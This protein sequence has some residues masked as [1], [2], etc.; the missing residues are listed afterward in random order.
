M[1]GMFIVL[2]IGSLLVLARGFPQPRAIGEVSP[3]E[4][5][6]EKDALRSR[7]CSVSCVSDTH[8]GQAGGLAADVLHSRSHAS[9]QARPFK[10][11]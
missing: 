2:V 6:V 7:D 4:F 1:K 8:E 5:F 11:K 10:R 9:S 3:F